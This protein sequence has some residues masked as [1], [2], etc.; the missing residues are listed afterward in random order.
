MSPKTA[1]I[2]VCDCLFLKYIFNKLAIPIKREHHKNLR[3]VIAR[4]F[5]ET[6]VHLNGHIKDTR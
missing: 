6:G 3:L 2:Y 4:E 5:E 1:G